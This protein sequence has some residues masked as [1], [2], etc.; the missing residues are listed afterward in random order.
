MNGTEVLKAL[1]DGKILKRIDWDREEFIWLSNQAISMSYKLEIRLEGS[2]LG[3]ADNI[4]IILES[5]LFYEWE[6]VKFS[7]F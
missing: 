2:E 6:E 4:K 3:I 5:L 7:I 1:E